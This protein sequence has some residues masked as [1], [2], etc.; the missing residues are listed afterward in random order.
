MK[1]QYCK[2]CE[3]LQDYEL[4]YSH[5]TRK[6]KMYCKTCGGWIVYDPKRNR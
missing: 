1:P 2:K 3:K 5:K 6:V 4:R